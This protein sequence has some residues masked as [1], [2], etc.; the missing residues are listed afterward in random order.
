VP[1]L[2]GFGVDS[3]DVAVWMRVPEETLVRRDCSRTESRL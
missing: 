1:W 2:L 3:A